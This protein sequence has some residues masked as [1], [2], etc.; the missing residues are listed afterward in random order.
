MANNKS[1][2]ILKRIKKA[3]KILAITLA[4]ATTISACGLGI[5]MYNSLH[6]NQ[7]PSNTPTSSYTQEVTND[8][9]DV[10]TYNEFKTYDEESEKIP[11]NL[12]NYNYMNVSNTLQSSDY[13]YDMSEYFGL[14]H[15]LTK[16]NSTTVNKSTE[17]NLLDSNGNIDANKLFQIVK[18]NNADSMNGKKNSINAF[19]TELD[20][21]TIQQICDLIAE[22]ANSELNSTSRQKLANTLTKLTVFQRTGTAANA[23]ISNNLTF[24]YNPTMTQNYANVKEIEGEDPQTIVL[25]VLKHEIFHLFQYATNDL[26]DS[27]G[28]ESGICRMYNAPGEEQTVPVDS[29]WYS[30]ALEG[31][32]ELGMSNHLDIEPGT[33]AKK[34]SYI[35]SYNLSRF[36]E[37]SSHDQSLENAIFNQNL[38]GL[39]DE[40]NLTDENEQQEFLKYMY[41][42]EITQTDPDDF[43]DYYTSQ[44]GITPTEAEK[45]GIRMDIRTDAVKYL[46]GN[47]YQNLTDAIYEGK[48]SDLN[49]VFYLMRTWEL[50]AYGHLEYTKTNSLEHAT[51]F[52]VWQ[53]GIQQELFTAIADSSNLDINTINGLYNEYNLQ[54]E[55]ESGKI[56]NNCDLSDFNGYTRHLISSA[57]ENYTTSHFSRTN[58]VYD[59]INNNGLIVTQESI[60][61]NNTN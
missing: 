60:Q 45:T 33:Y 1:N 9:I 43:W 11:I 53:Q 18:E 40:L 17:S 50:D 54:V 14:D 49:T 12:N 21:S 58:D 39:Y 20:S 36:N 26:E 4:A 28:I 57:I 5:A 41:A 48:I 22:T 3:G 16:Y 19:Y 51:D 6:P 42:V 30:W 37:L 29:L 32:A 23:Y 31:S 38:E 13:S 27:N 55:K 52:I 10:I 59:Y 47:F 8:Y 34:I 56:E 7:T 46:T 35:R 61:K 15:A 24:V 2:P 25:S 44:T